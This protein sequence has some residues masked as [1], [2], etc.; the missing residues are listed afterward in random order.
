MNEAEREV[1]IRKQGG[2]IHLKAADPLAAKRTWQMVMDT[3]VELA[4]PK[5]KDRW[6]GKCDHGQ[7]FQRAS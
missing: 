1:G 7:G 2:L 5:S 3:A 6:A 4:P